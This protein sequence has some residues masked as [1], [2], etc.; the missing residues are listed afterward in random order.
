MQKVLITG[1]GGFVGKYLISCL[2]KEYFLI[3]VT[4]SDEYAYH[5]TN[6]LSFNLDIKNEKL[7]Y[8]SLL[9]YSSDVIVH[10]AARSMTWDCSPEDYFNVNFLGTFNLYQAVAKFKEASSINPKIIYVSSAQIYGDVDTKVAIDENFPINPV[11]FYGSSKAAGDILSYQYSRSHNLKIIIVRAFNHIGPGQKKGFLVSD[12]ASQ[13]AEVKNNEGNI[14]VGNLKS[15]RDYLDV[16]DVALGYKKII[17]KR[18]LNWGEAFNLCSGV[19][20]SGKQIL[21]KLISFSLKNI[22]VTTDPNKVRKKDIPTI[23]GNNNK[24]KSTF[25]W[26]PLISIDESLKDILKFWENQTLLDNL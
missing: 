18:D 2:E 22:T 10:L 6:G 4:H 7:I 13:I 19:D 8:D 3:A 23:V 20:Y 12:I 14:R 26:K 1:A 25:S 15:T 5:L 17:E 21:D 16:R 9:K 11:N 24:F